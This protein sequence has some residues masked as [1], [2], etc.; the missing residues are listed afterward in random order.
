M[1]TST[2]LL[3]AIA[4]AGAAPP[5]ADGDEAQ[6][7]QRQEA[8]AQL[9]PAQAKRLELLGGVDPEEKLTLFPE[10]LLRWSNPTAGSVHGEVF[11][12]TQDERPAAISSIYRWY[13][14]YQDS[15]V[16]IVSVSEQALAAR[17]DGKTQWQT[18]SPGLAFQPLPKAPAPAG[19]RGS[20]LIQMRTLA[21]RFSADLADK[22]GGDEVPRELRLLNQPA[23]RY[24][25]QE[26]QIVDGCLFAFVEG[27]DPEAWLLL[28][29]VDGKGGPAWRYAL[30]RMNV[31]PLEI[32]LDDQAVQSW[33]GLREAWSDRTRP[34]VMFNFDPQR[35]QIDAPPMAPPAARNP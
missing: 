12:W 10:P 17:E 34:Y 23:H 18:K 3:L 16:E 20:R 2:L 14:P 19:N 24:E 33:P 28:E 6:E 4:A 35:V 7:R 31:D 30:A 27:T 11:L 8:V 26:H 32:C 1:I 13:H 29:V 5:D 22:R 25:S 9:A 15:T 21:R